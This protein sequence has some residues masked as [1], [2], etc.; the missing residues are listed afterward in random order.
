[1]NN[2]AQYRLSKITPNKTAME[3]A[4]GPMFTLSQAQHWRDAMEQAG[5]ENIMVVNVG[6][7]Q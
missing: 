1:M 5:A 3:S 7:E 2:Q 4:F 6:A